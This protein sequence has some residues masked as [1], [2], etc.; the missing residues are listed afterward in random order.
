MSI[1][2]VGDL[3]V[4]R[5]AGLVQCGSGDSW[6]DR[7]SLTAAGLSKSVNS[8]KITGK[9]DNGLSSCTCLSNMSHSAFRVTIGKNAQDTG[10]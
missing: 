8:L 6:S 4:M 10:L 1:G 9:S 7:D 5:N 2:G 3:W